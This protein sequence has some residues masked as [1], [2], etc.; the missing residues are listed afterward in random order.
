M[1][2]S[3]SLCV[4]TFVF[5]T[6]QWL[7]QIFELKRSNQIYE[8]A[9]HPKNLAYNNLHTFISFPSPDRSLKGYC[10]SVIFIPSDSNKM[11]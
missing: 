1:M 11:G 6:E 10:A 3:L 8:T 9:F 7:C 5:C 4:L 2:V